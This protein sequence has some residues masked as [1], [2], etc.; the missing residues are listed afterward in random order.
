MRTL[1]VILA[2]CLEFFIWKDLAP[3]STQ[4]EPWIILCILSLIGLVLLCGFAIATEES[5]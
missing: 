1:S 3:L 2:I 5:K 4:D